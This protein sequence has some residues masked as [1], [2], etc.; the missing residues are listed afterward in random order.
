MNR[1]EP[2]PE[3]LADYEALLATK[4]AGMREAMKAVP[5]WGLYR[6]KATGQITYPVDYD[7][8]DGVGLWMTVA[9][10]PEVW[11]L[12]GVYHEVFGIRAEDLEPAEKTNGIADVM[13]A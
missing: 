3:Q 2:T 4:P 11:W 10:D 1:F 13:A 9:M 12:A 6:I 5:P 8:T 7:Y